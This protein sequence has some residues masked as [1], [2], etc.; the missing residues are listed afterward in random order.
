MFRNLICVALC[1]SFDGFQSIVNKTMASLH[2]ID[3]E[4]MILRRRKKRKQKK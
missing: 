2:M 3:D 4:L 1:H